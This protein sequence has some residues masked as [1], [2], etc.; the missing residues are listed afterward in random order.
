MFPRNLPWK[1]LHRI[2]RSREWGTLICLMV[3]RR[4][5]RREISSWV[6]PRGDFELFASLLFTVCN[7]SFLGGLGFSAWGS[8]G[9]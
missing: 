7:H 9:I 1:W 6:F 5:S 4:V 8:R 3:E 2:T